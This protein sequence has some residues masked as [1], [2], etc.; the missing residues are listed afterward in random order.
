MSLQKLVVVCNNYVVN[1][2]KNHTNNNL[3][4]GAR[5]NKAIKTTG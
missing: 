1:S 4:C 3:M 5:N 2:M